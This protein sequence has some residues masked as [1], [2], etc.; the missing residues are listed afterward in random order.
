MLNI[1][2]FNIK[3]YIYVVY[4]SVEKSMDFELNIHRIES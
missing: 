2:I 4:I 1:L 3:Y